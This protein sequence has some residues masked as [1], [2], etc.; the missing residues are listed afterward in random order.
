MIKKG[1]LTGTI[2][3]VVF[4]A[5][6]G[7]SEADDYI[8]ENYTFVDAVQN[9]MSSND[10]ALVYRVNKSVPDTAAELIEVQK[11]EQ[12]GE[13]VDGRQVLVYDDEFII[14]TEDPDNPGSTLVEVAEDEFVR[15]HYN[16]GFFSG[17]LLGSFL[18]GRFGS[19]WERTQSNKCRQNNDDCYSGGGYY[20][21]FSSGTYGRGSVFRG[22]GPGSG[23]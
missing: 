13:E 18:N 22:G 1:W 6:C 14:L 17:M 15:T 7:L 16:P 12:I 8:D 19:N 4:L 5:A 21:S 9:N 3:F 11:P 2:A 10:R 23:K 20:G